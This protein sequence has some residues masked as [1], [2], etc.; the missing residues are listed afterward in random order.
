MEIRVVVLESQKKPTGLGLSVGKFGIGGKSLAACCGF[1][2]RPGH[3]K[4]AQGCQRHPSSLC[5]VGSNFSVCQRCADRG[6]LSER[7]S[8]N[9]NEPTPLQPASSRCRK[10][11]NSQTR[12][13][14]IGPDADGF[15]LVC[16]GRAAMMAWHWPASGVSRAEIGPRRHLGTCNV[17]TGRQ[18]AHTAGLSGENVGNPG[19]ETRPW[20]GGGG[21]A[22]SSAETGILW[23]RSLAAAGVG[24]L[25]GCS[26]GTVS[27][28]TRF[29][30]TSANQKYHGCSALILAS[31]P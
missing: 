8:C 31:P 20:A 3:Y 18:R 11:K 30:Q 5:S 21:V 15:Y 28:N 29:D 23:N 17:G 25:V 1:G 7:L 27:L 19:R 2:D 9:L 4:L 10:Q 16:L 22:R 12:H 13:A 24:A 6:V 14:T 26:L